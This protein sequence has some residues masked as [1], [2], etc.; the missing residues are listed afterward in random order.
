MAKNCDAC[1]ELQEKA[2]EF[3]VSGV[4][5][6][7]CNSLKN[8]KGF[9]TSSGNDDCT[10]LNNAN[11]CLVGNMEDEIDA[12]DVCDWKDYTKKF[13][14]NIWT[15]LKAMICAICGLWTNVNKH[16]CEINYLFR[17]SD[18]ILSETSDANSY[19]VAGKGVSFA[20]R[21]QSG[22][23]SDVSLQYVAGGLGRISGSLRFHSS[24][25]TEP[26]SCWHF[27][28]DNANPT[29]GASRRG[30]S[31]W[32]NSTGSIDSELVYEMRIKK[33]EYPELRNVYSG[34]GQEAD[35]GSFHISI[36]S[37]T[38]AQYAH[39]Q[40]GTCNTETG[41]PV[42]SGYSSGHKV[43]SGYIYVQVRMTT[44]TKVIGS[45]DDANITPRGFVGIRMAQNGI[46]C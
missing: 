24:N 42:Q 41:S 13:V 27:D 6:S 10:D 2:A 34:I 3:V 18:F 19:I 23:S 11:D 39:G 17:G 20:E 21:S 44:I 5:D 31:V 12:Y 7:V 33:A 28:N 38:D 45:G 8:D 15:V 16:E 14:H 25:W 29:Y 43:K 26:R 37:F 1:T 9:S 32:K 46:E 30:N 40:H 4:T 35:A 36:V 22:V